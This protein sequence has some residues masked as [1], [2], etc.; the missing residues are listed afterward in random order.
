[1][2][3]IANIAIIGLASALRIAEEGDSMDVDYCAKVAEI[4]ED[5]TW[6]QIS[7]MITKETGEVWEEEDFNDFVNGCFGG[8]SDAEEGEDVEDSG[9]EAADV[10]SQSGSASGADS[11]DEEGSMDGSETSSVYDDSSAGSLTSD[12]DEAASA[13]GSDDDEAASASGSDDAASG[14]GS[15]SGAGSDDEGSDEG[16]SDEGSAL[17]S[18]EEEFLGWCE[19]INELPED[20]TWEDIEA[21]LIEEFGEDNA[22]AEEEFIAVSWACGAVEHGTEFI[23]SFEDVCYEIAEN[24]PDAEYADVVDFLTE[25][26]GDDAPTEDEWIAINWACDAAAEY[27]EE[28][29]GEEEGDVLAQTKDL[30]IPDEVAAGH[31]GDLDHLA[32]IGVLD[33]T[34]E[35]I[36]AYIVEH[37]GADGAPSEAEFDYV[38][39]FCAN[40]KP[41]GE[42][43]AQIKE[44]D[45][46]EEPTEE[47]IGE[48]I[49]ACEVFDHIPEGAHWT[50]IHEILVEELGDDA[51]EKAEWLEF[52]E[53]CAEVKDF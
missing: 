14:S 42:G 31:C 51:P 38:V 2:K 12:E 46:D 35:D 30:D 41:Q 3:T 8:D 39:D 1:M 20:A 11:T 28:Y 24:F 9:D 29:Y 7:G 47:D 52:S 37:H 25:E 34:W 32:D 5:A 16:S 49:A 18:D 36:L 53:F 10:S 33:G 50:Q 6:D 22:P 17:D 27:G 26:L 4:P 44:D 45:D 19:R 15:G 13:S 23:N 40:Q 43:A 48:L 21:G